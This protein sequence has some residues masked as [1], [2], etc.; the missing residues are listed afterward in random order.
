MS[1]AG[2][3][4]ADPRRTFWLDPQ[5]LMSALRAAAPSLLFGLRLWVAVCLALY[6]AFWLE[7]DNAYWAGTT[8]AI[9]CQPRLGASLRKGWFR[10]IGTIVGAVAIVVLTA[11]FPQNRVAFLIS[12]ALWGAACALV[13]TLLRNFAAYAAALSGITAAIIASDQLGAVGGLNGQAFTLAITR[14]S[15]IC[16]GIV[17][18]GVVLAAADLG[19]AARRLAIQLGS[20]AAEI[21]GRFTFTLSMAGPDLPDTR[22]D[23]RGLVGRVAALDT[24]IDEALGESAQLR[25]HSPVF[26]M[27]WMVCSPPWPA[28]AP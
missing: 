27:R 25:Y 1:G 13:S 28:G 2:L 14:A 24:V 21:M 18:A 6:I 11:C 19:G 15:E 23:R 20:I 26:Q 22:A 10:M 12:L 3:S 8:A 17:C 7:L 4:P 5:R 9:V 16:I